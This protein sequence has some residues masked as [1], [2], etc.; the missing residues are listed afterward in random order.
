L[1]TLFAILW[2]AA[3]AFSRHTISFFFSIEP[4]SNNTTVQFAGAIIQF[5][6]F[7]IPLFPLAIFWR[8]ARYQAIFQTLAL[9]CLPTIFFLPVSLTRMTASQLQATLQIT[10][11]CAYIAFLLVLAWRRSQARSQAGSDASPQETNPSSQLINTWPLAIGIAAC[12]ITPWL[13]YGALGSPFDTILQTTLGF[14]LGLAACL[15]LELFLYNLPHW[16]S[17]SQPSFFD[18]LINGAVACTVLLMFGSSLVY[19]FSAMQ[20]IIMLAVSGVG[21][22][23]AGLYHLFWQDTPNPGRVPFSWLFLPCGLLAGIAFAAP[24][25]F[26]DADELALA[27][28]I[29]PGEILRFAFQAAF[30]SFLIALGFGLIFALIVA[31]KRKPA[32]QT[33]APERRRNW[34]GILLGIAAACAIFA[35]LWRYQ[36][37]G[38][39]GWHGERMFVIL[40]SQADLGQANSI[41]NY[42][43]RRR[44]AY[45][46][47]VEHA[48]FTQGGLRKTLDNLGIQYS[49][50]YLVNALEVPENPL[51]RLY[52]ASRPEVDR[53][54]ESPRLRPLPE[55]LEESPGYLDAPKQPEWNLTLIHAD[56][57]WNELGVSGEGIIVGQSDS[58]VQVD[59]P[60]LADS[61]RGKDGDHNYNWYDPWNFSMQP[62]DFG[63]HG[64]H[65]LGSVL[66]N[67][68]GVAPD[69]VWI[70]CAN[71]ARNLGNPALYLDCWQFLFAPFPLDGDPLRDGDPSRGAHVFNNSWGCPELEGCDPNALL[72][73][74]KALR[75]AGVFVVVSAGNSGPECSSVQDPP[76]IYADVFSVG[77]IS[78]SGDITSF[79]SIGPVSIDGSGRT[80]PDILAPGAGVLSA[81]P[82]SS[83]AVF[84]GTSMAGPHVT[85]VVALMWSANPK[86]IGNID[87][88]RD[89]LAQAAQP[90]TGNLPDCPG[91]GENPSTAS[92]AGTLDAFKAVILALQAK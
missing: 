78:M 91:A 85:G 71:L 89:L 84:S 36:S 42:A 7:A 48:D 65:T 24:L 63:G 46:A 54:L 64:T 21:W 13:A 88:T 79:S 68:T 62:V 60:E 81:T 44:F 11:T 61:Y 8:S 12:V 28:N 37:A 6:L 90:Y 35:I 87:L 26:F 52:L 45:Q 58:G 43:E 51:L 92:G 50:Y 38:Q 76:A 22:S 39:P 73:A 32:L 53:I 40:K 16:E 15:L 49:P 1:F 10:L 5:I 33:P 72:A 25:A 4:G 18:F 67:T 75:D 23:I 77:A 14:W 55:P 17:K 41:V 57:V 86:L 31:L 66:G 27:L 19:I 34:A 74:A 80:K 82:S 69:A 56:Q 20:L 47:L 29:S 83:Y 3:V 2:I 59:H 30:I 9:A 70:G